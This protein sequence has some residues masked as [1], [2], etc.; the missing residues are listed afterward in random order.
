[1]KLMA[2]APLPPPPPQIRCQLARL[3]LDD[4]SVWAREEARKKRGEGIVSAAIAGAAW[5]ALRVPARAA[6]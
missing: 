2:V 5:L 6:A 4:A 1:L 3:K